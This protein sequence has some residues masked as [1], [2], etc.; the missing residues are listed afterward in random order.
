MQ[1]FELPLTSH[2]EL[3]PHISAFSMS[4]PVSVRVEYKSTSRSNSC[5]DF[6]DS[7]LS[8]LA[9]EISSPQT[10]Y[11]DPLSSRSGTE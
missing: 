1:A 7:M 9:S 8:R 2:E 11:G 5:D 6:C 4:R 10:P 3:V